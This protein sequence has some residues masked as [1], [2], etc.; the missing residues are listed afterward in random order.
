[1][2]T[3]DIGLFGLGVVGSG[4]LTILQNNRDLI[5]A[6]LG[7][8]LRVKRIVTAHP[9]KPRSLN[10]AG[11]PV[12]TDPAA[13]LGDPEI[14][15]VVEL[16]GGTGAARQIVLG[17]LEAGKHVVTANKA[18]L[19]EHAKE[20]F[21]KVYETGASLG[22]EAA[23]AGGI[24]VLRSLKE[25]L[26]A[27]NILE[28]AG[29]VNGTCN[30][31][32]TKMAQEQAKFAD[33][34]AEAQ[35]LGYAE[36]DP[37]FDVEGHDAAHKLAVLVN[38][39]YG[40]TVPFEAIYREGISGVTPM[41]IEFARLLGY[42]IKHLAIGKLED[43]RVEARVHPTLV[44]RDHLL[45]SVNGVYN[46]VFLTGDNV[47][48]TMSYGRG[49]G[50]LPT[51]S[52]V[53]SD[54]IDIA[55]NVLCGIRSRVPALTVVAEALRDLPVMPIGDISSEY[56]LR[57]QVRDRAGVLARIT[58]VMGSHDISI[59]SMIQPSQADHPDDPV[60]VILITHRA[61]ER[62]IRRS[63]SEIGPMDFILGPTQVIRIERV[64]T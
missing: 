24:P 49:A 20:I 56:Y 37:T 35:R 40:T 34:L 4:L 58:T 50:G 32:L 13:I 11:I 3:I 44:P 64:G 48:A 27:D 54:V 31:I 15:I 9:E 39:A 17:A 18:L 30:Y 6:R 23:V 42:S 2:R 22:M 43:G 7:A 26:A 33:V 19:A 8:E 29:I 63:L 55:R 60:Q 38:L 36:A 21:G 14:A 25:G 16:I 59:Q 61:R 1:M 53:A 47:D 46:A 51:G 62:D 5:R 28:V 52:A 57:F 12:G 10:L 45:A 41:D